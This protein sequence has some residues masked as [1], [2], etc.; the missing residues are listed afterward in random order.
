MRWRGLSW[1]DSTHVGQAPRSSMR[2]RSGDLLAPAPRVP[3]RVQRREVERQVQLVAVAV[4]GGDLLGGQQVDLAEHQAVA[5][6]GVDQL[7]H[8]PDELVVLGGVV[9]GGVGDAGHSGGSSGS[10]GVLAEAVHDVD[11]EA[12]D[13][14]VEPEAHDPVHGLDDLGVG[15][16]EVGLLGQEQVQVPLLRWRSSHVQAGAVVKAAIQLLGGV[17]GEPSRQM[18]QSRFGSSRLDRAA[19]N[20]GCWSEVWLGT[21]STSSLMSRAWHAASSSSKSAR[22]PNMRVDVAVVG[23][24]VAEVGLGRRVERRDPQ[25]VDAEPVQVVEPLL[26]AGQ[27][28]G[29]PAVRL[30]AKDRG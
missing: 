21:R 7:A 26:D 8:A 2:A 29:G 27:V 3:R 19:R 10:A 20:H 12:V 25:R 24:V 5:R 11:A 30:A 14:A 1:F 17:S 9:E 6:V 4:V 13:A 18:Y 28:T 22:S 15:P 23:D 16:V